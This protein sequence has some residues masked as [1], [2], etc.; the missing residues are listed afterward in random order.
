MGSMDWIELAHNRDRWRAVVNA[1]MNLFGVPQNAGNSLTSW[2]TLSFSWRTLLHVV[3]R[4]LFCALSVV[5][6]FSSY[7]SLP[8][9]VAV[10]RLKRK[11]VFLHPIETVQWY[12]HSAP[13]HLLSYE[14]HFPKTCVLY[15]K[16]DD[17]RWAVLNKQCVFKD[18]FLTQLF[19][20][21]VAETGG[22]VTL[23]G[24]ELYCDLSWLRNMLPSVDR[25]AMLCGWNT[26]MRH[27]TTGIRYEKCVVRR[28]RR[29][30]NVIECTYTNLDT[31][32]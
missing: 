13:S 14:I 9:P 17:G 11:E 4:L 22:V 31:T 26:Y 12:R 6:K 25:A 18:F 30:A 7:V 10:I 24:M 29:C 2:G 20:M 19:G 5:F 1:M 32:V 21:R 3:S 8:C 15:R 27:L 23:C 28:F 16:T